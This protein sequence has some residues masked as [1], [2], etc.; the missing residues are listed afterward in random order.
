M[1]VKGWV[2]LGLVGMLTGIVV[3]ELV[4][5]QMLEKMHSENP[6][7][8]RENL[9]YLAILGIVTQ[10]AFWGGLVCVAFGFVKYYKEKK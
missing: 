4:K 7:T 1:K 3:P 5:F 2:I 6:S 9:A 10:T 8:I